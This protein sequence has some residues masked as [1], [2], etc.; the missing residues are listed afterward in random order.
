MQA[1]PLPE[2]IA[3]ALQVWRL[4]LTLGASPAA[5]DIAL[6]S[7]EEQAAAERLQRADDRLRAIAGRAAL[8]RLLGRATGLAPQQLQLG[9]GRYGKPELRGRA[10]P[11]F[12]VSHA[13]PWVLIAIGAVAQVGVDLE[14]H[15]EGYA[16]LAPYSLTPDERRQWQAERDLCAGFYDRWSAKEAALKCAGIG[17]GEHLQTLS[18][19]RG[20]GTFVITGQ[21]PGLPAMHLIN[22]P[23]PPGYSAA[24]A[25]ACCPWPEFR[26]RP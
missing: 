11:A 17:I 16:E 21:P 8:R 2:R 19:R 15:Q 9:A 7:R 20:P 12:N 26:G 14:C 23:C 13:G 5:A 3:P 24:L 1:L 6:L 18:L 4:E 10:G 25:Y 22:L